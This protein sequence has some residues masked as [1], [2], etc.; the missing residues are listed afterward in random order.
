MD[1]SRIAYLMAP[2]GDP[3]TM[4]P[5]DKGPQAVAEELTKWVR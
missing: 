3:I 4:L 1:H 5:L 2:N